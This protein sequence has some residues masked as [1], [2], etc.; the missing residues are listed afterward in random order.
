MSGFNGTAHIR[1]LEA[2]DLQPTA[3]VQRLPGLSVSVLDT[4]VEVNIDDHVIGKTAVKAKSLSPTWNEE[5]SDEV[6][7]FKISN[8][9]CVGII[10][11]N[12]ISMQML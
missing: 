4:F 10:V 8:K 12:M 1:V 2:V 5:F 11:N 9:F 6:I 7:Y 3:F